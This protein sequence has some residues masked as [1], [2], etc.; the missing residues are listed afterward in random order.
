MIEFLVLLF[1]FGL[2]SKAS[3]SPGKRE[4]ERWQRMYQEYGAL[5]TQ[6]D[7]CPTLTELENLYNKAI[8]FFGDHKFVNN[9]RDYCGKLHASIENRRVQLKR[10]AKLRA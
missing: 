2:L 4:Y 6:I 7:Y 3:S 9:I 8:E 10:A 5:K 1:A